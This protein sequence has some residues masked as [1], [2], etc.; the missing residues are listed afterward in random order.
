MYIKSK[1]HFIW[2]ANLDS[3]MLLKN[4]F[5]FDLNAQHGN[6]MTHFWIRCNCEKLLDIYVR[7]LD[8]LEL[9]F[10]SI[11]LTILHL[12]GSKLC[13][14]IWARWSHLWFQNNE[15][16]LWKNWTRKSP[17]KIRK[18]FGKFQK[19]LEKFEKNRK[20]KNLEKIR[21]NFL[22]LWNFRHEKTRE[23]ER[24]STLLN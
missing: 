5:S 10:L 9:L 24:G 22:K 21:K 2:L 16:R 14:A 12:N 20:Q 13:Y 6:G 3:L 15:V 7:L 18:K 17:E 8:I 4:S 1:V 19:N 23:N 11:I